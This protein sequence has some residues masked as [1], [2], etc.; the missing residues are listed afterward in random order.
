MIAHACSFGNC[1]SKENKESTYNAIN[2]QQ[3]RSHTTAANLRRTA[4]TKVSEL[5]LLLLKL[6]F[7]IFQLPDFTPQLIPLLHQ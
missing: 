7:M 6:L 3:S 1:G 2:K 4:Q 5:V